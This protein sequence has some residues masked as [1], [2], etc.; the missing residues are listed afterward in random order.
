M[1][2]DLKVGVKSTAILFGEKV[3]P[4]LIGLK[5]LMTMFLI[6]VGLSFQMGIPFYTAVSLVLAIFV[7][8]SIK[9][10]SAKKE[11]FLTI[12]IP[13]QLFITFTNSRFATLFSL[14]L[15]PGP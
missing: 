8:Q 7:K 2:D 13:S 1:D 9:A 5:F 4:I 12:F 3:W 10:R 15:K 14:K 11:E 6:N